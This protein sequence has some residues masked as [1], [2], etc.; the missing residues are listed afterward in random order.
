MKWPHQRGQG[1][2]GEAGAAWPW[3]YY[4]KLY[5]KYH[6]IQIILYYTILYYTILCYTIL[7]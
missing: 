5:Y 2:E 7:C 4:T 6:T 3:R 1:G